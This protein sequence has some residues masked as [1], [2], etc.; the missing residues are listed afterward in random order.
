MSKLCPNDMYKF[1]QT[2]CDV[3]LFVQMKSA[4]PVPETGNGREVDLDSMTVSRLLFYFLPRDLLSPVY[5]D[6]FQREINAIYYIIKYIY[7][8]IYILNVQPKVWYYLFILVSR[9]RAP[10]PKSAAVSN[11]RL[12]HI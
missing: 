6:I 4:I 8:Y 3:W 2:I 10:P 11:S 9:P 12:P 1:T 5:I 7:I